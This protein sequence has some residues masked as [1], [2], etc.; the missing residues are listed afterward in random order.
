M[1]LWFRR[2]VPG[3]VVA[4]PRCLA[5]FIFR[6]KEN[7]PPTTRV[8]GH[9]MRSLVGVPGVPWGV[10]TRWGRLVEFFLGLK[11]ETVYTG[12]RRGGVR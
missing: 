7:K 1:R 8:C 3:L 6:V 11:Q 10:L 9:C 5:V 4:C 2:T 12:R